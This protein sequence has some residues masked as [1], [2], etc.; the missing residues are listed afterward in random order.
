MMPDILIVDD[1]E[2]FREMLKSI[3]ISGFPAMQIREAQDGNRAVQAVETKVPE[4]IFLDVRLPDENGFELTRRLKAAHADV[5]II[6][7][8]SYDSPEYKKAAFDAGTDFFM[9]KKTST[10]EDILQRVASILPSG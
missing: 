2:A 8:T 10:P 4:L 9:S 5:I 3:L 1:N 6:M 7:M